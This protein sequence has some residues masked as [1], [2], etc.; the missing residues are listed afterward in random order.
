MIHYAKG[1]HPK[2]AHVNI[3][4]GLYEEEFG[5]QGFFGPQTQ[6]YHRHPVTDWTRI[7]GP[8]Q[9]RAMR[10]YDLQPDDAQDPDGRPTMLLHNEDVR[11]AISRRSETM[12]FFFRNAD[13]DE[14]HFIHKGQGQVECDFGTMA[15][16][17]GDYLLM[18]KGTSYRLVYETSDNFSLI[19]EARAPLGFPPRGIAGQHAPF[20]FTVIETPE[21]APVTDSNGQ[22]WELR[23]KRGDRYTSVFYD[24]CPM[25]VVGWHGSLSV[26]KL[27]TR[28]LRCLMSEGVHLP[29]SA[30]CTFQGQ[31]FVVCTFTPRPLEGDPAAERVPWYHR[32]IDYDEVFFIHDGEFT[33]SRSSGSGRT[34]GM[35]TI[36]PGGLHHGPHPGVQEASRK[37]WQK[38]ARLEFTAVNIDT[39]RPLTMTEAATAVEIPDYYTSWIRK[40]ESVASS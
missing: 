11:I 33:L 19:V 15:F 4:E 31:G 3:P 25:D 12:P 32:N 34:A 26:L 40:A 36:N 6:L 30:H 39:E 10:T 21:P 28:D 35:M 9:P 13:G 17:P 5:R 7:E 38:D 8:L 20:D 27:N 23:I 24:F 29:P 22:E 18:P 16:E 14:L 2:Q 37:H 1:R